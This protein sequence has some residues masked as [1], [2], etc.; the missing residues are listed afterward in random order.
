MIVTGQIFEGVIFV[1]QAIGTAPWN[2][3][4]VTG[5]D[6][7]VPSRSV[8]QVGDSSVIVFAG[9]NG[10]LSF[11]WQTIGTVPWNPEAVPVGVPVASGPSSTL[12]AR[13][14]RLPRSGTRR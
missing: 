2:P 1:G 6:G 10:V 9:V 7:P 4:T 8:A 14:C 13:R 3:E 12:R 5:T 11:Y